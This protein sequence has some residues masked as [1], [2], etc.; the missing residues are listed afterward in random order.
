VK[1]TN[2]K[3]RI[4]IKLPGVMME[5]RIGLM[6]EKRTIFQ[7]EQTNVINSFMMLLKKQMQKL[8]LITAHHWQL[9]GRIKILKYP[10]GEH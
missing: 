6:I 2:K 8:K 7:L 5:K 9:N 4:L 3:D 10:T 1:R